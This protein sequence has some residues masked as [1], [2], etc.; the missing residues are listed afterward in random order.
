MT[1]ALT[2][3]E[4]VEKMFVY[5]TNL[6]RE[7]RKN[8]TSKFEQQYKGILF[9]LVEPTMRKEVESWFAGRDKNITVKHEK[10]E[11]G[12]L[13]EIM[14]DYSGASK[15]AHFK[16][17]IAAQFTLAGS[18]RNAPAYLKAVNVNVDKRNVTN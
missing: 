6:S 17:S 18:G 3:R 9:E 2:R 11:M 4:I 8:L 5:M 14:L 10:T 1:D 15:D 16:F 13:G 7:C 12:R